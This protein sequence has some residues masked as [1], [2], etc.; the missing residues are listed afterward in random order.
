MSRRHDLQSA[1]GVQ[2]SRSPE[3]AC[4]VSARGA[5]TNSQAGFAPGCIWQD[6]A[7]AVLYENTGTSASST[8]T[9]LSVA[10]GNFVAGLASGY[11]LYRGET[12]LDGSNPTPVA[13]GLTT[14]VAASVSLSGTAAPGLGTSLLTYAISGATVNVYAWK[15]TSAIDATL[16]ASTGTETF[17]LIAIGT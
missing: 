8:W 1:S 7:N 17:S 15:V 6:V 12:A 3:G 11:K 14:V 5:P 9:Q 4:F 10:S 13:T 2:L 16:I